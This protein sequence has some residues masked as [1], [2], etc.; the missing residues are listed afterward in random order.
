MKRWYVASTRPHQEG[1]ALWQL[2]QQGFV[3]W[4]P[5]FRKSR[6]HARRFDVVVTPLF[7]GYVFIELEANT[8]RWHSINGTYGVRQLICRDGR[9]APL[10]VGFVESFQLRSGPDGLLCDA[11]PLQ[12]GMEVKVITG[13]FADCVGTL[14]RLSTQKRVV[15][16]MELLAGTVTFNLEASE[17]TAF[18]RAK[19]TPSALRPQS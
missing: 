1:R 4:Y 16:L 15:V 18:D 17:V 12:P 11:E 13:P 3:A 2:Q 14:L 6:R 5:R 9:P 19:A 10:P 7:N 8:S